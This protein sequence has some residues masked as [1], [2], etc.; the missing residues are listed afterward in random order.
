MLGRIARLIEGI[1]VVALVL[2]LW[3]AT[4]TIPGSA[5]VQMTARQNRLR[6]DRELAHAQANL[7]IPAFLLQPI[8]SQERNVL[9]AD[10]G[11][12]TSAND[13]V[14]AR[15]YAV[16]YA[17][18]QAVEQNSLYTLRDK[19]NGDVQLLFTALQQ[20]RQQRFP[21]VYDYQARLD[22]GQQALATAKTIADYAH[23]DAFLTAQLTALRTMDPAYQQF[24]AFGSLLRSLRLAGIPS[25][26]GEAAYVQDAQAFRDAA[27]AARYAA[28]VSV[29][30]AQTQQV[31][32][33]QAAR[34]PPAGK[35]MLDQ[36]GKQADAL[37]RS[38]DAV[39]A[40]DLQRRLDSDAKSL[41]SASQP[42]D[43][44]ALAQTLD[45]QIQNVTLPLLRMQTQQ[46]LNALHQL[47]VQSGSR[48][49]L[50][51]FNGLRYPA[52]YEYADKDVGYGKM[53]KEFQAAKTVADVQRADD[54]ITMMTNSLHALLD[55]QNDKTPPS[56]P[57]AT[58]LRLLRG[59]GLTRGKVI[60]VS[61]VEQAARFY[62]NG[63][64]VY[65]SYVTTGRIELPS[66]PG[67]HFAMNKAAP[68]L[69]TSP[70]PRSSPF[71]FEPTPVKYAIEYA[72]GGDFL[73][74]A[75]W[76]NQFGPGTN[77]PHYDPIAFNGGSHGCI[78]FP[79]KAMQWVYPWTQVGTPVLVY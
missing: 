47:V 73:H 26:L 45:T 37:L 69:F 7:G 44:L 25:A 15:D 32:T 9:A 3:G 36:M 12:G 30:A 20:A 66:P 72:D 31:L 74:D 21:Y 57:H 55:D 46:D 51:Q 18:L 53:Q 17:Q 43:Y 64:L 6:L 76:R 19:S 50:D 67:L 24:Q 71:W 22:Q 34:L 39:D 60:V 28:L 54:D 23:V 65:W 8:V 63:K 42:A 35:A 56:K 41:A 62:D 70:E 11:A 75:W 38:G 29:I 5:H 4:L 16:L 13:Q 2:V 68:V 49:T 61:L 58:D 40:K 14:A 27:P 33:A 78:N 10:A 1:G 52:A 48:T 77:L 79:L 59:D